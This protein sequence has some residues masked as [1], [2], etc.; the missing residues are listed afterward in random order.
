VVQETDLK[1]PIDEHI[2]E[3]HQLRELLTGPTSGNFEDFVKVEITAPQQ[4]HS[5]HSLLIDP[6]CQVVLIDKLHDDNGSE[7]S[8]P[9]HEILFHAITKV[10]EHYKKEL[11]QRLEDAKKENPFAAS[12][13]SYPFPQR[14]PGNMS[15]PRFCRV[16]SGES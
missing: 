15:L 2:F 1:I 7:H 9:A 8:L 5:S 16:S 11:T 14:V 13:S 12:F 4:E 6:D 3:N 10:K